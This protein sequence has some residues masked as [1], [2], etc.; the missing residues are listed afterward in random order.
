M[1]PTY[2]HGKICYLEL[3]AKDIAASARFYTEVFGWKVRTRNDGTTG[4]D[5]G[6]GQVSGSWLTGRQP[7]T[8]ADPLSS[9]IMVHI[10]VD[11]AR[12][13]VAR[14]KE[15]GGDILLDIG[16]YAP[17]E[18]VAIFRDPAGNTLGIYQHRG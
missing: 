6:V 8:A 17:E 5:D 4:F 18:I 15:H 14:I 16:E 12:A 1:D 11:D 13:T 7:A 2:G 9:G 3:P 10:M